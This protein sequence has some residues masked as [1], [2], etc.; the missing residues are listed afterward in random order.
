MTGRAVSPV[1]RWG[2]RVRWACL[3]ATFALGACTGAP[4][5]GGLFTDARALAV[6]SDGTLWVVDAGA[7]VVIALRDGAEVA[8]L[9]GAGTT[10][11]SF[12]DP[13]DV[14]PTNGQA[15]FVAD[16]AAGLIHQ[17]TAEGRLAVSLV[18]PDVDP[19]RPTRQPLA[20]RDGT[21][22][23][24]LA[25]AAAP[26]GTLYVADAGRRHVLQLSSDG[27]V[28]RVL[29]TTGPGALVDPVDLAV[30]DDGTLWVA[31]AARGAL[32]SFDPFGAPGRS[33]P[34]ADAGRLVSVSLFRR[35]IV[36]VGAR[37]VY[38]LD[39]DD[40]VRDPSM[41]NARGAVL[42]SRTSLVVLTPTGLVGTGDARVD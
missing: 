28:E 38:V 33:I 2:R 30:A 29:G 37:V 16:R 12:L 25:V 35:V 4:P 26:D 34:L 18:V 31:D 19:A 8:R 7:G 39:G 40:V 14:D 27:D 17:F 23:Q 42:Q 32:Q 10:D 6:A 9:G 1:A 22:G 36:A 11:Q 5:A 3:A 15:I 41:P 21:R 13:V 24:P 20:A